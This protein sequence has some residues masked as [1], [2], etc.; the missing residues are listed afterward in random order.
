MTSI[1][2]D[3]K[4][5][6]FISY[7][8]NDNRSGAISGFVN[9]LKEELAATLKA[10]LSIYFDT[11]AYDGLM[12]HHDVD[13][14]LA[15]KLKSLVFIPILSQTYCDTNSFAWQQE[16]CV[17]NEQAKE[18]EF[19]REIKLNN[20]NVAS[21]IL[22]VKIHDLDPED[23]ALIEN[24]IEGPLRSIEFIFKSA[25]VNRPLR[26]DDKREDNDY[27]LLYRDQVNKVANAIKDII[28]GIRYPDRVQKPTSRPVTEASKPRTGEEIEESSIAV[29]PFRNISHDPSQEYFADGVTEN[30]LMELSGMKELRVISRT[31]IMRYKNSDK[32]AP[33]IADE[34]SVRYI[35]EG[36]AQSHS[37]K[38]R[39]NAQLIQAATDNTVWS[40]VFVESLEDIFEI[41][42][43]VAETVASELI[44]TIRP[45]T[46]KTE[47]DAPTTN[48]EAY[49]LF[50]KGRH[51]F[52]QWSVDG[53]KTA[54]EY[55]ERAIALDPD[56]IPAY[57]NLASSYSARMSWNGDLSPQEAMESITPNLE[58]AWNRGRTDNDYLTKA[59]VELFVN[60]DFAASETLL[61]EGL[62]VNS[63]N[64]GIH[65]TFSYLLNMVG[66]Y[67]EALEQ[68][69]QARQID[70]L[71]VAYYN[72]KSLCYYFMGDIGQAIDIVHEGQRLYPSVLRFYDFLARFYLA[73]GDYPSTVS[74]IKSGLASTSLRPPSMLAYQ[75][76]AKIYLDKAEQ[77][78]DLLS[79]L[80]ERSENGEKGV[81]FY[82]IHIYLA[83]GDKD[84]AKQ[85]LTK[86]RQSNDIDL[87][88]LNVDP[89]LIGLDVTSRETVLKP[90]YPIAEKQIIAM[91]EKE[92]PA[93]DYH[94]MGHV[95]DVLKAAVTIAEAEG[96][97]GEDVNLIR[98]AALL[99]DAGFIHQAEEHE[100][101][102][103]E[104]AKEILPGFNLTSD[105]IATVCGMIMATKIPQ[106]P[107][108]Q[109]EE[110]LCD[111]DLDYLGRDDF[112]IISAGLKSEFEKRGIV[113]SEREWNLVQKTFFENHSY[114][115]EFGRK[116]RAHRKQE[117][118]K[119]ILQKLDKKA[120]THKNE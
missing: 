100:K 3:Y 71:T 2:P 68:V 85:W 28:N 35:L 95:E 16:F 6:I 86:A 29:L 66:R 114:H 84:S 112:D 72:F 60:K 82:L 48:K 34:L 26:I 76:I 111:A 27:R 49:D 58:I 36:S 7:R 109:L 88:W 10:P 106:M 99:H 22:P 110:I 120:S 107:K 94:N 12:E 59:F 92:L 13:K 18:D 8:H 96:V 104:I 46:Q 51:A 9:Y 69:E 90:D 19:G 80:L 89:L 38:V 25:G 40:K 102:S 118:Y 5:D 78:K 33:E 117:H 50:L 17:F 77:A 108:N 21:R 79:E 91:L 67:E 113:E 41:Q 101:K 11:N 47:A 65:Y 115:T 30:I 45:E 62:S 70:P 15:L 43:N 14:S 61:R 83:L 55:F 32:T 103:V 56:F 81:N 44:G 105:Q 116:T 23:V 37:N 97:E 93:L 39:I 24:E 20:G 87:I 74:A 31:S 53:Y 4:Y 42:S 73:D 63:N 57:S 64:A 52:N 119:M 98:L 75:A 54:S 1:R